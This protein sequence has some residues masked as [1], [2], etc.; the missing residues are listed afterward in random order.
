MGV[1]L[2]EFNLE[3]DKDIQKVTK[4][5]V[6]FYAALKIVAPVKTGEFR[7]DWKLTEES[8]LTWT[9]ENNMEYAST[10]WLG[11][12]SV[13]GKMYGSDQWPR[14][15]QPMYDRFKYDLENL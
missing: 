7:R 8:P 2:N 13:N 11:R 5:T 3:V 12:R 1:L 9:I 15:G 6:S 14:G 10:L 4:L